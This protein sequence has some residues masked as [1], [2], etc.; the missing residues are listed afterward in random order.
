MVALSPFSWIS[1]PRPLANLAAILSRAAASRASMV[2]L[3]PFSWI[4]SPRPLANLAAI[5]SRAAASRAA[6]FCTCSRA[7]LS[8]VSLAKSTEV[9]TVCWLAPTRPR[10]VRTSSGFPPAIALFN[11]AM[12]REWSRDFWDAAD[13]FFANSS[14][15]F[16]RASAWLRC[17]A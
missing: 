1:S 17:R 16:F 2:A 11:R 9:L 3:S 8:L 12:L 13:C 6:C 5:L 14:A 10:I 7:N 4:S 15:A